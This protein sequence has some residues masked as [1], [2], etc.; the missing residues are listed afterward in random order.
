MSGPNGDPNVS[1]EDGIINDD[2]DFGGEGK[3]RQFI[4]NRQF[5][6]LYLQP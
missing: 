6:P 2:D 5:F 4:V 3:V 1:T